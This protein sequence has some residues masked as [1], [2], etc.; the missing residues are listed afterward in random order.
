MQNLH[1]GICKWCSRVLSGNKPILSS[2]GICNLCIGGMCNYC[3]GVYAKI[4]IFV[5]IMGQY[6][7]NI[8]CTTPPFSIEETQK[9]VFLTFRLC[10]LR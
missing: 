4:V 1:K 6:V 7:K 9:V 2:L 10:F 5:V 8:I 3:R